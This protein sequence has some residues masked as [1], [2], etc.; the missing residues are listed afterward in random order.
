MSLLQLFNDEPSQNR[1]KTIAICAML[2]LANALAWTW[3]LVE[4]AD[5]PALFATAFLAY[6]FGLRHA[7]DADHIAAIDNVV[8]KLMQ[9]GKRPVSVGFFFSLG[10]S[11]VVVVAAI[12]I[13]ATTTALQSRFATFKAFGGIIGSGVSVFFLLTIAVVNLMILSG[14]WR[15]FQHVRR[16][17]RIEL[18]HLEALLAGRGF[19]ARLFR[20]LF[21]II[22]R[23]WH[24]YPLGLLFA[25]GFD[26]ATEIGLLGLSAAQAAQGMS[27][28]SI[29][30]F[31]ALFTAA[32]VLVDTV[33][34]LFMVGAYGWAFTSPVRKLWYNLTITA[35]SVLIALLIGGIE[36]LGLLADRFGMEG[37][38]WTAVG[39]LN[40][41]LG[42]FGLLV[43][44]AF[45]VCWAGSALIFGWKGYDDLGRVPLA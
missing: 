16:G 26:T 42:T 19:L 18:D 38:F 33:D 21:R 41:S 44:A 1:S 7:V 5:R 8:R 27:L 10:H 3:A 39:D 25:L 14:V 35:M 32:M 23:S 11:T 6:T 17:G 34:G 40:E 36:A 2:V 13:A 31:P 30:I 15:S 9:E 12:G 20:G 37:R 29:L 22:S 28:W 24:M 43:I 45:V 4:L